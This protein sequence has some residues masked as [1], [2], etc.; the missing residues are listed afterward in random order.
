MRR[1]MDAGA[2]FGIEGRA[3]RLRTGWATAHRGRDR[4]HAGRLRDYREKLNRAFDTIALVR[5]A[6][7][8]YETIVDPIR[9]IFKE[10]LLSTGERGLYSLPAMGKLMIGGV[11]PGFGPIL[12]FDAIQ[13]DI[14]RRTRAGK[15]G[16]AS[17][18]GR[19]HGD[20]FLRLADRSPSSCRS[21]SRSAP[22]GGLLDVERDITQRG[23]WAAART[24]G[25]R[26]FKALAAENILEGFQDAVDM[27]YPAIQSQ[28]DPTMKRQDVGEVAW[29]WLNTQARRSSPRCSSP[30]ASAPAC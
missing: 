22:S 30:P 4:T 19:A 25:K 26:E 5:E 21:R 20:G 8:A 13:A 10:G 2:K 7:E 16:H 12:T 6:Q 18:R 17:A 9:P 11:V 28:F 15:P 14:Y 29:Q 3:P 24:A 1:Q 23:F 27:F